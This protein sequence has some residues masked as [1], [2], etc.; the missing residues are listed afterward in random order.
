MKL[1][2]KEFWE[3]LKKEH[4]KEYYEKCV[5]D[6]YVLSVRSLVGSVFKRTNYK[7][8][9]KTY[10]LLGCDFMELHSHLEKQFIKGMNWDNK[11]KWHIDHIVP[12]A[13]AKDYNE[14][15]KLSHYTNLQPLWAKDNHIKYNKLYPVSNLYHNET[16]V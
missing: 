9:T 7:K 3:L 5:F 2:K 11:G 10:K 1:T 15:V 14:V 13:I 12:I 8:N 4:S 6:A 16:Y